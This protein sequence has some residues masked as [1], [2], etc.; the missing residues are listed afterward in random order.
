MDTPAAAAP[1]AFCW[2]DLAASDDDA[3]MAFYSQA[4]GWRF[5]T[6]RA[7]GGR[8]TRCRVGGRDVASL[9]RLRH[10]QREQGVPSHWTP[11]LRVDNLDALV[12]RI[13]PLGGRVLVAPFDVERSARIALIEDAVGAVVGLWQPLS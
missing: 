10:A 4:F 12:P 5:A 3:A 7:N 8:F 1:G 2:L 13:A 9:Y 11:Y 6:Q